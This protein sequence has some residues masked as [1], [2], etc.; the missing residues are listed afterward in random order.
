MDQEVEK[1][2]TPKT[3]VSFCSTRKLSSYLVRAKLYS[4]ERKGGSFKCKGQSC[5][6]CLNVDETGFFASCIKSKEGRVQNQ[7]LF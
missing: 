1:V 3:M 4:L 5:L 2:F 7:S 6:T